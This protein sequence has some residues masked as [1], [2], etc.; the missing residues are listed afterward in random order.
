MYPFRFRNLL[1]VVAV[2]G[3]VAPHSLLRCQTRQAFGVSDQRFLLAGDHDCRAVQVAL[4]NRTVL[5]VDQAAPAN[6]GFLRNQRERRQ[7]ANLDRRVNLPARGDRQK[8]TRPP[9]AA[10][11]NSTDFEPHPIR[12]NPCFTPVSTTSYLSCNASE[13]PPC[14]E[15]PWQVRF[16]PTDSAEDPINLARPLAATKNLPS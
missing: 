6:Q 5:Q 11:H 14:W 15:E 2:S 7:I 1:V 4:A 13:N 16:S 8:G 10:L 3:A 9:V 12:E